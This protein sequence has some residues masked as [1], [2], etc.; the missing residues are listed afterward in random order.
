MGLPKIIFES[1]NIFQNTRS[2]LFLYFRVTVSKYIS[3][4]GNTFQNTQ[5]K[6]KNFRKK[7]LETIFLDVKMTFPEYLF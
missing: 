2:I 4:L 7:C 6:I 5:L 1:E 3:K